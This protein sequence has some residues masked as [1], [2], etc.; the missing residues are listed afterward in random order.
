MFTCY[1]QIVQKVTNLSKSEQRS[2]FRRIRRNRMPAHS[3]LNIGK[4]RT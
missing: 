4:A 2:C 1:T 3:Q